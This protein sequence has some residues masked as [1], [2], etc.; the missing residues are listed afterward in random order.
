MP[1]RTYITL[2]ALLVL[3]TANAQYVAIQAGAAI[4]SGSFGNTVLTNPEDGFAT[5]GSTFSLFTNYLLTERIGL[6]A[7]I[8]YAS[9]GFDQQSLSE[10]AGKQASP[11]TQIT[12]SSQHNYTSSSAMAGLSYTLGSSNLTFDFRVMTGFLTLKTPTLTTALP[13]RKTI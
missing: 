3:S 10:Q 4:P 13:S 9:M 11:S 2:F 7:D 8:R 1:I 6:C 12:A 5:S